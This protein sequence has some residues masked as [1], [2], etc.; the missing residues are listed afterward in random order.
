MY[1]LENCANRAIRLVFT[2]MPPSPHLPTGIFS[3]LVF[4]FRSFL[5][6]VSGYREKMPVAS[7]ALSG[8]TIVQDWAATGNG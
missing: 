8:F 4:R 5:K 1:P 7:L 6:T 3:F 2:G